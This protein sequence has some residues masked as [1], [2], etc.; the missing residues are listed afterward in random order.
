M[1]RRLQFGLAKS[2]PARGTLADASG[3]SRAPGQT[4]GPSAV[5]SRGGSG[6]RFGRRAARRSSLTRLLR[7][8]I[9][10]RGSEFG[11]LSRTG[12]VGSEV[13]V[14]LVCDWAVHFSPVTRP[15][16]C[17]SW[18]RRPWR[19][20]IRLWIVRRA[21][22][23][24]SLSANQVLGLPRWRAILDERTRL[25]FRRIAIEVPRATR[26]GDNVH[27]RIARTPVESYADV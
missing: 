19:L 25:R 5:S 3:G 18:S 6:H 8:Q 17:Q 14:D 16:Y 1:A 21:S 22:S 12:V 20:S 9:T 15:A 13:R 4:C 27:H 23:G 26:K 24:A 7:R 2:A 11:Q 10:V